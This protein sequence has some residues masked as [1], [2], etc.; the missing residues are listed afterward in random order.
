MPHHGAAWPKQRGHPEPSAAELKHDN[1]WVRISGD[2]IAPEELIKFCTRPKAG[3]IGVFLGTTRDSFKGKKVVRLE[4][5]GFS[6]MAAATGVRLCQ[7]AMD[8]FKLS[9]TG[10]FHRLGSVPV[11]ESSVV[12]VASSVHRREAMQAA[13]WLI[14]EVKARLPVWK[15]EWY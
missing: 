8:T 5:E 3:G 9:A 11:T 14:D 10:V 13:G 7:Q 2:K 15:L 4:Y 6:K 1:I 12:V